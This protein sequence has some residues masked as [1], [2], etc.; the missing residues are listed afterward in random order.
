LTDAR[1]LLRAATRQL[2]EAGVDSPRVDAELL[3]AHCLDVERSKLPLLGEVDEPA[4][5]R[6]ADALARRQAREPL[7]HIVGTAPFRHLRLAVGPGVFVPRPETELLV[8]AVLPGLRAGSVLV[9]LCAGSGALGLA[10]ADEVP[11]VR[12]FAVERSTSALTWLRRNRDQAIRPGRMA[13]PIEVVAGDVAD[14]GLLSELS[15]LVDVVLSNP[16]YV[17]A[18]APVGVEVGLDPAEAVFAGSDGLM[19]MPAVIATSGRLLRPGG[20]LA[21]EHDDSHARSLPDLLIAD[22]RWIDVADHLDLAGR[23]RYVT[24]VRA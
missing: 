19:L 10:V 23:P 2:G 14:A 7:Q 11:G 21:I 17:P 9:D 5:L 3:L 12:V 22:G 24:A 13:T 15:G 4:R 16:P 6:F 1:E 18:G 20:W 8:D